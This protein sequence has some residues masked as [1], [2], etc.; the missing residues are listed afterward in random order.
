MTKN[1]KSPLAAVGLGQPKE[2][3]E[4][5]G[6]SRPG[7][8]N[9]VGQLGTTRTLIGRFAITPQGTVFITMR[10]L[11]ATRG[12]NGHVFVRVQKRTTEQNARGRI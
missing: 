5:L 2:P 8:T 4:T 1:Q 11:P 9:V 7:T 3:K 10:L 6:Y 12:L